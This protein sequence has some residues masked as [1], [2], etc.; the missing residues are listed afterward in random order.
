MGAATSPLILGA[1]A[2][3]GVS[4]A[5]DPM[6]KAR[7]D[8]ALGRY[9]EAHAEISALIEDDP[10]SAHVWRLERSVVSLALGD[11]KGSV[12]DLR[13]ARDRLDDLRSGTDYF[14]WF[15]SVMLDDRQL[16]YDGADYEHVLVRAMLAL[17]DLAIGDSTDAGA[18]ALQVAEKQEEII[19]SFR[20]ED[21]SRPKEGYKLVA[22]GSYLRAIMDEERL[23]PDLARRSFERVREI[24]PG[25][26]PID[27]DLRRVTEGKH[28]EKG[29]GVIWVIGLVGRGPFRIEVDEP[30]SKTAFAMA[31]V[32]WA[33]ARDSATI[34]NITDVKIPAIALYEDNPTEVHVAVNGAAAG[35]T[36]TVTDVNATALSEF[37]AMREHIVARAVVRRAFKIIVTE[38]AKEAVRAG[39]GRKSYETEDALIDLGISAL[40]MLWTGLEGADLR[41]WSLL[42]AQFQVLRIEV[43]AGEHELEARAGLGGRAVGAPQTC[44]VL[45]RD[46]F[47]TYVLVQAPTPA[48]GPPPL[49]SEAVAVEPSPGEP[50]PTEEVP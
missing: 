4:C 3:L 22:F 33:M 5:G 13:A 32:I 35:W 44:R 20:A 18:Y 36:A 19:A 43:P 7:E 16:E 49:S 24:E 1:I 17:S 25:F 47:N 42:P 28:S 34:P 10:S 21:E 46:G 38:A 41:C 2:F 14:G 45:V 30:V 6:V 27:E 11:P 12:D 48:G 31:Q 50:P 40:G 29:N 37:E 15:K 9:P 23:Q 26:A 39:R 8:Y